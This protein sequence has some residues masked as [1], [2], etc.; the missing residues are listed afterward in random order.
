MKIAILVAFVLGQSARAES[1]SQC[2]EMKGPNDVLNCVV[3]SHSETKIMQSRWEEALAGV[4]AASQRPNPELDI[5]STGQGG[6]TGVSFLHTFELGG[7]RLAR[8]L[9]AKS[10]IAASKASLQSTREQLVVR[11]VLRLYRLRQINHELD[12]ISEITETFQRIIN[13][14]SQAGRLSPEDKMAV[15]VFHMAFEESRLKTS[16]LRNEKQEIISSIE[17]GTGR[18]IEFDSNLL[19]KVKR[20]WKK[21][22][23]AGSLAGAEIIEARARVGMAESRY[24]M[25]DSAA[26]Q[27]LTVGPKFEVEH[28]DEPKT[29][30]GISLSFPLP[31]YQA[32]EGK[33]AQELAGVN[34]T[35]LQLSYTQTR[36][37]RQREFLYRT[38]NRISQVISRTLSKGRI[39]LKHKDLHKLISRGIVSAPIVIE[40]HRQI[41]DYYEI[42]HSQELEGVQALWQISALE[43]R[44]DR[45]ILK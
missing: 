39:G 13:Q 32:N 20:Q 11:T 14:Y 30:I 10:E 37:K 38:Y 23:M 36:L 5:E 34:A 45:E 31:L 15:S 40:M 24:R 7:K 26:W 1:L 43:G 21:K 19:P 28:R 41:M 44:I 25:A 9:A 6:T 3:S 2:D 22:A 18:Q 4:D 35:K 16:T 33:K 17:A 8:I 12:V 29:R 42:L 27:N